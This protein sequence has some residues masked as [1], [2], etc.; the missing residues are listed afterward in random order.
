MIGDSENANVSWLLNFRVHVFLKSVVMRD[1]ALSTGGYPFTFLGKDWVIKKK[2]K[3]V[4]TPE[5]V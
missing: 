4:K 5:T 1:E 3:S 2:E